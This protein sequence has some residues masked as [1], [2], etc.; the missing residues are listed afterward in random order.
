MFYARA[1]S[2]W[3]SF[4]QKRKRKVSGP[5]KLSQSGLAQT[6]RSFPQS[7]SIRV[8]SRTFAEIW[9]CSPP[10]VIKE[11][12]KVAKL[13]EADVEE[14]LVTRV[15][16]AQ[17]GLVWRITRRKLSGNWASWEDVDPFEAPSD[18]GA[19][20]SAVKA[21][22]ASASG[23]KKLKMAHILDQG[24]ESEFT[25]AGAGHITAWFHNFVA[26]AHGQPDEEETKPNEQLTAL[27][28]RVVVQLGS[29]CA[30]L[31]VFTPYARK[32]TRAHPLHRLPASA[33]WLLAGERDSRPSQ[34]SGMALLLEGLPCGV[35]NVEGGARDAFGPLPAENREAGNPVA[36]SLAPCL[37]GGRQVHVR[38]FQ[39]LEVANRVRHLSRARRS[40]NVGCWVAVVCNLLKS[41]GGR[42]NLLGR[43]H[44]AMSWLAHGGRGSPKA[45]EHLVA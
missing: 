10:V 27:N 15:E 6:C 42:R 39:S 38:A 12:V 3:L 41:S 5:S 22:E 29:P 11:A 31:A 43:Q 16:A 30:D 35:L 20:P 25:L 33:G 1:A 26:I 17:V 2:S 37:P 36:N 9:Q 28:V 45:R 13:T 24:D 7:K 34:L 21:V 19:A 44:S 32:T 23:A 40:A 14:R 18:P 4:R 8:P